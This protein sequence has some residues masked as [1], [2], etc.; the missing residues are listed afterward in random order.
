MVVCLSGVDG[1]GK[2]TLLKLLHALCVRRGIRAHYVWL[3][4]FALLSYLIYLYARLAGRTIVVPTSARRV[5]VHAFWVDR[6]LRRL[7][8]RALLLDLLLYY[9]FHLI[10]ALLKRADVLLLD[11]CFLDAMVDLAWETRSARFLRSLVAKACLGTLRGLRPIV[12]LVDPEVAAR[13]KGDVVSLREL[14]FKGRVYELM[15]ASIRAPVVDTTRLSPPQAAAEVSLLA[16][17]FPRCAR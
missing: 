11:R 4:W 1:A 10:V 5:H 7:Y 15:A 9:L 6:A 12:L 13:R 3:R 8:P 14:R 17:N 16:G 2:T